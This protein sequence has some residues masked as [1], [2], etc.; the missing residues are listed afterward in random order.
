MILV[1]HQRNL[2][3]SLYGG[4]NQML[5]ERLTGIFAGPRTG[6]QDDRGADFLGRLHH[7]LHL[8]QVV[9]VEGWNA[10][11]VDGCMVQQ[12]AHRN[13]CHFEILR[14]V[15]NRLVTEYRMGEF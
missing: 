14:E 15:G 11:A 1:H 13:E 4:L 7:G 12:L 2:W 10:V 8:L 5:D 6:L 9:H 3:I